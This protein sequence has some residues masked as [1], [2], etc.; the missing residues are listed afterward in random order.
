[1]IPFPAFGHMIPFFQFSIALARDGVK[2]F[3]ISTPRNIQRLPKV[4]AELSSLVNFVKIPL[5]QLE[6]ELL[7]RDAE[8]TID[9]PFEKIQYL[10]VAFDQLQHPAKN[11]IVDESPDYIFT[12]GPAHWTADIAQE[13]NI[14]LLWFSVF[15]SA[16]SVFFGPPEYLVGDG[17]K[18]VRSS[19]ESLTK[20]PEWLGFP[21]LVSFRDFEAIHALPGFY[22]GNA[23]GIADSARVAK[24]LHACQA[25]T[26]RSCPEF[27]GQYLIAL[28]RIMGKPV[29]P[30]GLLPPKKEEN[31]VIIND[32]SAKI[33][34][35]L[36]EQKPNTVVFVGFGS[37]CKL[38]RDQV[39]EIAYGLEQSGLPF[40]WALRKPDW[41][42][43]DLDALPTGFTQRTSKQGLVYIGWAPQMEILAHPSIGGALFHSGWG[44]VIE[45]LQFG[46]CLVVL[47]LIID[48]PLNA[49]LLV[50][51]GL[52][53]EVERSKDGSFTRYNIAE[54]L[55]QAMLSEEGQK[56]RDRAREAASVFG[57]HKLHQDHY[58]H[59]LVKYLKNGV[60]K[61]KHSPC[62]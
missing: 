38:F 29:I 35:W 45:I 26:I 15:S 28:E 27:E 4:P 10:K 8:A 61:E 60:I 12:D 3:Y 32:S 30:V 18:R 36:D 41:A 42:S 9:V 11:F 13:C 43:D 37:E 19:P 34:Q 57:D 62:K 25:L 56:L 23:S 52:A 1:M 14:P 17:Q 20:P 46:H 40:F 48:Q 53:I 47:P 21:S 51:K 33:F 49:R 16:T 22:G 2:V 5:P 24:V 58:V 54:S 39:H 50:E 7:P 6:D 31:R 55:R 59:E 44:S